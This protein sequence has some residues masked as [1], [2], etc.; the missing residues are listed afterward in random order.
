MY[1][2]PVEPKLEIVRIEDV[3]QS[4][5]SPDYVILT[6]VLNKRMPAATGYGVFSLEGMPRGQYSIRPA[7]E[8]VSR[9]LT[10]RFT[11]SFPKDLSVLEAALPLSV[12]LYLN[13][14]TRFD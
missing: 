5:A 9:E 3:C 10:D 2:G 6:L 12:V 13:I 4:R 11:T 14:M 1:A 8:G 7:D